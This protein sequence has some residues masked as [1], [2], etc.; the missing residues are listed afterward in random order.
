[1]AYILL[2]TFCFYIGCL[3]AQTNQIRSRFE[4]AASTLTESPKPSNEQI[5]R[6]QQPPKYLR[7]GNS[8]RLS[9]QVALPTLPSYWILDQ[10]FTTPESVTEYNSVR[11][12]TYLIQACGAAG[13]N[14]I[15]NVIGGLGGCIYCQFYNRS[16]TKWYVVV[17]PLGSVD[18]WASRC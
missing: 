1:V 10:S 4:S 8:S 13:M 5:S 7:R 17:G 9:L 15:R 6:S 3:S 12:Y 18:T 14:R 16:P 11:G 2:S